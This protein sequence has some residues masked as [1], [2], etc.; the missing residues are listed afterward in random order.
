MMPG[1]AEDSKALLSVRG[2]SVIVGAKTAPTTIVDDVSF[3]VLPHERLAIVGESGS[4]KTMTALAVM[5]LLDERTA[6]MK[7]AVRFAG[8]NLAEASLRDL[9]EIRG[10][11]IS[12]IPQD[13]TAALNPVFPIG[14]QLR[15]VLRSHEKISRPAAKA[16]AI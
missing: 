2:L 13:P 5:R 12:Y 8:T 7:G 4:G 10:P 16:R 3:D 6:S 1:G 15:A 11:S 14:F 9:Q